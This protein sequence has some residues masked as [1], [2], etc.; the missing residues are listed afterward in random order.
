PAPTLPP[1]TDTVVVAPTNTV[2]PALPTATQA[3]ASTATA[4]PPTETP[5]PVSTPAATVPPT[6]DPNEGVGDV[7]YSDKLDGAGGWNWTFV[8]DAST[9]GVSREQ[10][11]LNAVAKKSGTWRFVISPDTLRL[12]D[13]QIRVNVR[14]N[15]CAENDEYALLF[16][17]NVDAAGIYSFYAF[18]LRCDGSAK[19]DLL[20]GTDT[21]VI[22]DWMKSEAI[23]AGAEADNALTVWAGQDQLRF[24]AN[25]QYLFSAQDARLTSGFYGFYLFD[26]TN[27]NMSVS[28]KN[29]EA[30]SVTA[31]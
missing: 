8:D 16:R 21:F 7:I 11:Q 27:G 5:T 22:V 12:S 18:K 20:R 9:F 28:W 1:P 29:L 2:A 3:P 6:P 10:Q 31:P 25:D 26:R 30:R 19:L 15:V 4:T 17:G 24:Y 13:Q 23:K 14:A